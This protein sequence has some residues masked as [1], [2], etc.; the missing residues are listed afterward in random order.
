MDAE[1]QRGEEGVFSSFGPKGKHD[2]KGGPKIEREN[3]PDC[4]DGGE[5][6][7]VLENKNIHCSDCHKTGLFDFL[8]PI[9]SEANR[10]EDGTFGPGNNANPNG[11]PKGKSLKEY[12]RARFAE[13]T[14]EQKEEFSLKVSSELLWKMAEGQPHITT[15]VTTAGQPMPLLYALR[16]N[17]SNAKDSQAE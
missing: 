12:W 17:E 2:C 10:R 6:I 9:K 1:N 13:M 8:E 4:R 15:D 14:D 16:N 5:G 3:C 11:R 7:R